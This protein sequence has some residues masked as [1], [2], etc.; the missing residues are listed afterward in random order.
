ML[1]TTREFLDAFSLKS[2]ADLPPLAALRAFEAV[3]RLG[4]VGKAADELHVTHGAVSQQLRVLE[5]TLGVSLFLRHGKRLSVTEDGRMYALRLRMALADLA[6]A[7]H[8]PLL[9]SLRQRLRKQGAP[10]SGRIGLRCVFSRE[11]VAAPMNDDSCATDGTLNCAGYGS[12]VTV[13]ATFG[14]VAAGEALRLVRRP[15][16]A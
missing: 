1:A 12:S 4:S 9:A 6:E 13:T 3:A 15:G 2:L 14:L 5:D 11:A 7:T 16:V 10:R 8:D